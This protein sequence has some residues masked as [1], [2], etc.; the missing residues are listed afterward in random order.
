MTP[1][2]STN[3]T[4]VR[5]YFDDTAD[6]YADVYTSGTNSGYSFRI[7]KK[8][9]LELFDKPEGKVLDVG[10]GP[11]V[12][13]DELVRNAGCEFWGVDVSP[14]MIDRAIERYADY[15]RTHFAVGGVT[16][17]DFTAETFDCVLGMGLLEYLDDP[18]SAA[19]EM[20]RVL[21]PG[22]TLIVT[23]PNAQCPYRI[24]QRLV[25]QPALSR[26]SYLK[27]WLPALERVIS[28]VAHREFRYSSHRKVYA[29]F[30]G[31]VEDVVYYNIK[32][33]P[34]PLDLV[35]RSAQHRVNAR[36]ERFGRSR[37]GL[38]GTGFIVKVRKPRGLDRPGARR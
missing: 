30:G 32:L 7:R 3:A 14:Q 10:C 6:G 12:V 27:R 15:P 17:L 37:L 28:P 20:Y 38:L 19:R 4:A 5:R 13:V 23:L 9:V 16:P 34:T 31:H 25:W 36:L 11:G 2:A 1:N 24:W 21:K 8:R 18:V 22:G 26:L 35:M 29:S 33:L